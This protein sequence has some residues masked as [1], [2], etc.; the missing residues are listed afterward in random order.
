MFGYVPGYFLLDSL[1]LEPYFGKDGE[2]A[3]GL[4]ASLFIKGW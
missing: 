4:E 1:Y 3:V 2:E